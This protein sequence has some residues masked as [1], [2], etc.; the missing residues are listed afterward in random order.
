MGSGKSTQV[1]IACEGRLQ[2]QR[3]A[4]VIRRSASPE[5]LQLGESRCD[6]CLKFSDVSQGA[7]E[8][9]LL[10]LQ[11][12]PRPVSE[13]GYTAMPSK[14]AR[15]MSSSRTASRTPPWPT[16]GTGAASLWSQVEA[17][18]NTA[19]TG[20]LRPDLTILL[21]FPA[22][23]RASKGVTGTVG[24]DQFECGRSVAEASPMD[25]GLG[26]RLHSH[27]GLPG[28]EEQQ[29]DVMDWG[30]MVETGDHCYARA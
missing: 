18:N 29:S 3:K 7:P 9:E 2:R 26:A 25:S 15:V 10:T 22:G 27:F 28:L 16:R 21:D 4:P 23:G 19:T 14:R 1:R 5:G 6:R 17:V 12:L 24:K 20:G 11:C 13:G 30:T 8:A